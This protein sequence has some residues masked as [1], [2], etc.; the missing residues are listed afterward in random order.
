M[1]IK[2]ARGYID[3]PISLTQKDYLQDCIEFLYD[4]AT[5]IELETVLIDCLD[6]ENIVKVMDVI[7]PDGAMFGIVQSGALG[8]WEV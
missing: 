4:V 2:L 7:T 8:Y 5:E 6:A 3:I 1:S